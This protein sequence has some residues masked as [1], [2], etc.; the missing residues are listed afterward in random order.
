[1]QVEVIHMKNLEKRMVVKGHIHLQDY[2]VFCEVILHQ[3]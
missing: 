3:F 2:Y 1:M